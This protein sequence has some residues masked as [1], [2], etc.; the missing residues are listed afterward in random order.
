MRGLTKRRYRSRI[1]DR[2]GVHRV[3]CVYLRRVHQFHFPTS[4]FAQRCAPNC[5]ICTVVCCT[6]FVPMCHLRSWG[7]GY[8]CH[9][10][11]LAARD[12]E[13]FMEASSSVR[14]L[15]LLNLAH[16]V[17]QPRSELPVCCT[18]TTS[19]LFRYIYLSSEAGGG[20][21][22]FQIV[23]WELWLATSAQPHRRHVHARSTLRVF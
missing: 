5:F 1:V 23:I 8:M 6:V 12:Q 20:E 22:Q 4:A 16:H 15:L 19:A 18:W 7:P 14:L 10:S 3:L 17:Q 11:T 13:P 21:G 9:P 2:P